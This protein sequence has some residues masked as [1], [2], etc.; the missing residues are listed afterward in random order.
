M[1]FH[2]H[3]D[4]QEAQARVPDDHL[5]RTAPGDLG[6][7]QRP[8][9]EAG[10]FQENDALGDPDLR[11]GDS[12]SV[13]R[14]GAR[15]S[16]CVGEVLSYTRRRWRC[17]IL[18]WRADFAQDWVAQLADGLNCHYSYFVKPLAD[19]RGSESHSAICAEV[20]LP[21]HSTVPAVA[22]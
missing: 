4:A 15:M 19:A 16:Q 10:D 6:I 3:E 21:P 2:L 1:P 7:H 14:G 11:R 12:A 22:A 20:R 9:I 8:G 13:T 18:H 17:R 5:L